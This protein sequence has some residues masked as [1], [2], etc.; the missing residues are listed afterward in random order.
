MGRLCARGVEAGFRDADG[1][2]PSP[3]SKSPRW[4]GVPFHRSPAGVPPM[5]HLHQLGSAQSHRL[6]R[7]G[8]SSGVARSAAH[9]CPV[10]RGLPEEAPAGSGRRAAMPPAVGCDYHLN[11]GLHTALRR[12]SPTRGSA[13][14]G[15]GVGGQLAALRAAA[16]SCPRPTAAQPRSA[17]AGAHAYSAPP[18]RARAPCI[19]HHL[20]RILHDLARGSAPG[21]PVHCIMHQ[22]HACTPRD[23]C[24]LPRASGA[25]A[26][27]TGATPHRRASCTLSHQR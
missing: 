5:N 1:L 22:R 18:D 24:H 13:F 7:R 25:S 21:C 27:R 23:P 2:A 19:L 6:R 16:Q 17:S 9:S 11:G 12:A 8:G 4:R 20:A 15:G 14:Q 3:H 26:S 10:R